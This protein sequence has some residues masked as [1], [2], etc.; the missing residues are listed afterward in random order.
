MVKLPDHLS[1]GCNTCHRYSTTLQKRMEE[2]CMNLR[3]KIVTEQSKELPQI[4]KLYRA[5]FPDNERRPL[6]PL[7]QDDT[8]HGEVL[9]FYDGTC[10]CGFACFLTCGDISHIIYF[11]IEDF[12]RG[13]GYG[14][15]ALSAMFKLKKGKRIIVDIEVEDEHE[16]NNT[17]RQKRKQFYLRNG[18]CET[19]VKYR[20]RQESY[21]ILSLGGIVSADEFRDFWEQIY[22]DSDALSIY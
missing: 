20:W 2:S 12:L 5:A 15:E 21:E 22:S 10:F 4:E 1:V 6:A 14:T 19:E 16:V 8:G 9:A 3:I 13:K 11:A 18:F 7:L 17:Q